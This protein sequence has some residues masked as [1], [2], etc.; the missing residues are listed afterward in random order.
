MKKSRSFIFYIC[1]IGAF[2]FLVAWIIHKGNTL[3]KGK[4]TPV[5]SQENFIPAYTYIAR[6]HE[7]W[8]VYKTEVLQGLHHP[9]AVLILQIICIM[10]CARIFGYVFLKIGQPLVIGEIMAGIF[11][12]PSVLGMFLPEVSAYVFPPASLGAIQFLS[13]IGLVL[14]M[15]IIGLELDL[16][17]IKNKAHTTLVISHVSI[18]F[19]YFLGV[20]LAYFLYESYA[21]ANITFLAF[22]LF[23]GI[24]MS[25][26]AFPVLARIIRDRQ[27]GKTPLGATALT[28]AAADDITAWCI[29]AGVVAIVKAGGISNALFTIAFTVIYVLLMMYMVKPWLASLS[30]KYIRSNAMN[31][32]TIAFI[33]ILLFSSSYIAELIGIHVLFGAFL[34][35]VVMPDK[36][37][38]KNL[39]IQKI[40]DVSLVLLLPLFF[41]FTGLRTQIGLLNQG[42]LWLICIAIILLAV[43]GKFVGSSIAARVVG[44]S[45]TNA[46][47]IG[48][49]MNTR[50][51]ME[52]IVLNIGFDLGIL[53]KEIFAMMV[54]MALV[55]TFMTGPLLDL[56]NYFSSKSDSHRRADIQNR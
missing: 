16:K 10:V 21:P 17:I 52:L 40:E 49:L 2:V 13:Q 48:A 12:G 56:I 7:A 45:W 25:I 29:L 44:E 38:L 26:T 4:L 18:I 43:V 28:C 34:A 41:V 1:F 33:F 37:E 15:F 47:S 5:V 54:I 14:F 3:E 22:S 50:G 36:P 9:I 8:E 51:L 11:L 23:M 27:L 31:K 39:F 20:G 53:S 19:P 24:A 46:F 32:K 35:G 55:T 30:K 42:N 6:I